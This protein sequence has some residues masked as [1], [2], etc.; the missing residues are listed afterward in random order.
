VSQTF[1]LVFDVSVF[2]MFMTWGAGATLYVVPESQLMGPAR[3]IRDNRLTVWYS[4]PSVVPF[5]LRMGM[6]K[7]G[8]FPDLRHSLF[9]GEPL[10]LASA[11]AWQ[12]AAPNSVVENTYGPTE[13]TVVCLGQTVTDP[14]RVTASRGIVA[15]GRPYPGVEAAVVDAGFSPL[16]P[17]EPGELVLAGGQLAKGYFRDPE[18]TS[19]RFP[20]VCG[21]RW[22]RT[23]DLVYQDEDL[24]FHHLG[25]MDNQVK[26]LGHRVELEEVDAHLRAILGTDLVATVAWPV[27]DGSFAGLVAFHCGGSLSCQEAR[28]AMQKRVPAYMV[29]AQIRAVE[30]MPLGASGKIDRKALFRQ[31]DN[32]GLQ[33][34]TAAVV[35]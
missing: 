24:I 29:P 25:R 10:P 5:M 7:P 26:V 30:A 17:G 15:I 12:A 33:E 22:Y 4:V 21:K 34:Q 2:D 31:L 28:E 13:A 35:K 6:L 1:E 9:I 27:N 8:G 23:G 16:P 19:A 14:P 11:Q 20:T 3:F 18:L 32:E